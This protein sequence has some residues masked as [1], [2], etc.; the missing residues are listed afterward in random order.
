[1]RYK[2]SE[3]L[4]PW[5]KIAK[6]LD[7][8]IQGCINIHNKNLTEINEWYETGDSTTTFLTEEM[9]L[10]AGNAYELRIEFFHK[11]NTRGIALKKVVGG[12]IS[13]V[14]EDDITLDIEYY[15]NEKLNKILE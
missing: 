10:T 2:D 8:S 1:M 15:R 9:D 3:K 4:T 13:W 14:D 12:T 6:K 11:T 5:R 7:L